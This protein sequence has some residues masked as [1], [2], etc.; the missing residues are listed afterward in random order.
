MRA[1]RQLLALI[2][3]LRLYRTPISIE[4]R[5]KGSGRRTFG[6]NPGGERQEKSQ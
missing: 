4:S 3:I 6:V 2:L 5:S 1:A